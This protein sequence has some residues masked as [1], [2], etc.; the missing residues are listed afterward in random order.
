MSEYSLKTWPICWALPKPKQGSVARDRSRGRP[1]GCAFACIWRRRWRGRR[2][3]RS[4]K[5][6]V[7][8]DIGV[9]QKPSRC[10]PG[11]VRQKDQARKSRNLPKRRDDGHDGRPQKYEL[12]QCPIGP[13]G[14]EKQRAPEHVQ[15]AV[16]PKQRND[17]GVLRRVGCATPGRHTRND[18]QHED[19]CP[20]YAKGPIGRLP[21]RLLQVLIP[22]AEIRQHLAQ[23]RNGRYPDH[24]H[25]NLP[26]EFPV[27]FRRCGVHNPQCS[28]NLAQTRLWKSVN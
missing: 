10:D 28:G 25:R 3:L 23:D 4:A 20:D 16:D 21:L 13:L 26:N 18:N 11:Q 15:N 6:S 9:I 12:N 17:Q 5:W 22:G 1:W 14:S 27:E 8:F 24:G 2:Y 7:E 19:G